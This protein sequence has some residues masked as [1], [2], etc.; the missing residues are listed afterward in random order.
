MIKYNRFF[1]HKKTIISLKNNPFLE[2]FNKTYV[3]Y[4]DEIR[5]CTFITGSEMKKQQGTATA[6]NHS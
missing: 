1:Y 6:L 5:A 3:F 2:T 4:V